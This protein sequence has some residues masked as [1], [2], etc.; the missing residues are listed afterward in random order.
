M[1][2]NSDA[3][4]RSGLRVDANMLRQA[5]HFGE[6]LPALL[7][8]VPYPQR[9]CVFVPF[10]RIPGGVD[11]T[12]VTTLEAGLRSSFVRSVDRRLLMRR[13][14]PHVR[15]QITH[16]PESNRTVATLMLPLLH[17]VQ[18]EM[19]INSAHRT[20]RQASIGRAGGAAIRHQIGRVTTLQMLI[21]FPAGLEQRTTDVTLGRPGNSPHSI[22][23]VMLSIFTEHEHEPMLPYVSASR[24]VLRSL[25]I[26][27]FD[28]APLGAEGSGIVGF[29]RVK[30]N[31]PWPCGIGRG[32]SNQN[33][34][35]SARGLAKIR[36][37]RAG[38]RL[39]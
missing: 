26:G 35:G 21:Q 29:S 9:V 2:R 36:H 31:S 13:E 7:A 27:H 6:L 23:S 17:I 10:Q 20:D 24:M 19:F 25:A 12:T 32:K 30:I 18:C 3:G 1:K 28:A 38:G 11:G 15:L 33:E 37:H 16:R 4:V 8:P 5:V 22:A 34:V 14:E 39:Q